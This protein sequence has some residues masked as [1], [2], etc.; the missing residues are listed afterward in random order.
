[1]ARIINLGVHTIQYGDNGDVERIKKLVGGF[2]HELGVSGLECDRFAASDY[3]PKR[4]RTRA[5]IVGW[6]EGERQAELLAVKFGRSLPNFEAML[7]EANSDSAL[8]D[9]KKGGFPHL[10]LYFSVEKAVT[11]YD[12]YGIPWLEAT[13]ENSLWCGRRPGFLCVPYLRCRPDYRHLGANWVGRRRH[14]C[15]WFLFFRE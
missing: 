15:D 5:G 4:W 9:F 11:L 10:A 13:C 3:D 7:N 12:R 8:S 14:I 1:M 6:P 2:E